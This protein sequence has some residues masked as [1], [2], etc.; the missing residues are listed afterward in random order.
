MAKNP[1]LNE[2]V[3]ALED[4]NAALR[5]QVAIHAQEIEDVKN[6]QRLLARLIADLRTADGQIPANVI[7]QINGTRQ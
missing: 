3:K 2:R 7:Q 5:H 4:E 6:G 1:S